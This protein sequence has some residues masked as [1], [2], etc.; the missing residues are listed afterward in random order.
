MKISN[1]K[2][3][4][5][6]TVND[7]LP[8]LDIDGGTSGKPI[9][10]KVSVSNLLSLSNQSGLQIPTVIK[11]VAANNDYVLMIDSN[12]IP[13]KITKANLLAGLSNDDSDSGDDTGG[14]DNTGGGNGTNNSTARTFITPGDTNGVFYFIGTSKNTTLWT[15]PTNKGLEVTASSV[16]GNS[17]SITPIDSMTDRSNTEFSTYN[18]PNNWVSFYLGAGNSLVCNYYTIRTRLSPDYYPRNWVFQGSNDNIN[19]I[20]LDIQENN[21][22]LNSINQWLAIPIINSIAYSYFRIYTTGLDS[23][24]INALAIGEVELYGNYSST[25]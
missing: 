21:N 24:G 1:L 4:L 15:N 16:N 12:D 3:L 13:Y 10:R 14:D 5:I 6:P 20:N 17:T 9:L 8:I 23:S 25:H 19:W 2:T 7:I 22:T 11:T 18:F